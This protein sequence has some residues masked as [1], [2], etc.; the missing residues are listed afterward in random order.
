MTTEKKAIIMMNLGG[1]DSISS[2]EPFLYNLF[3]DRDIIRLPFQKPTAKLISKFRARKV[4]ERYEKIGG[5]SPIV[6]ITLRQAAA[7]KNELGRDFEVFVGMRYWHPTIEEAVESVVKTGIKDILALPLFPQYSR[8]TTGTC[9]KKLNIAIEKINPKIS[10]KVIDRWY[11][12]PGYLTALANSIRRGLS[13][14]EEKEVHV[15]F[16]AH[17]L[18]QKVIEE[19]DPY[20][21][22]IMATIKGVERQLDGIKWSLG[23]QSQSGPIKWLGPKTEDVIKTLSEKDIK[24]ILVVPISFVSD[25]LET[26]YDIDIK[27]K[28]YAQKLGVTLRRTQSLNDNPEFVLALTEIVKANTQ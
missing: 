2:I 24:N 18:P 22:E 12:H 17:S 13:E 4:R 14:F 9:V 7:L 20:L 8:T 10:V 19:G 3:S 6:D 11:D 26:L 16:S 5:K 1:P 21:S 28:K 23:F 15:L 25:H 27:L